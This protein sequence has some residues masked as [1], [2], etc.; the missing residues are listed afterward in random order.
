MRAFLSDDSGCVKLSKLNGTVSITV[1]DDNYRFREEEA[2]IKGGF[3]SGLSWTDH[4]KHAVPTS[5]YAL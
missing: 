3:V 4:F 5:L 1:R 2:Q